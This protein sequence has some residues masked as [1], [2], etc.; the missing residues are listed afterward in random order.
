MI[1]LPV[2]LKSYL[3]PANRLIKQG[4]VK[5]VEFSGAT[6]QV[7]VQESEDIEGVWAFMQLDDNGGIKDCFCACDEGDESGACRHL[8]AAYLTIYR[9]N[10][11]P[12]HARFKRSLWHVLCS[13]YAEKVGY[14]LHALQHIS[15]DSYQFRSISGKPLFSIKGITEEGKDR[16]HLLMEARKPETEET[17]LKFSNLPQGEIQLRREGRPSLELLYHLSFWNDLAKWMMTL[18]VCGNP[19]DISFSYSFSGIPNSLTVTFP[20]LQA[21]FY[22]PEAML[23]RLIPSLAY[24]KSPIAVRDFAKEAID[25]IIYDEESGSLRV[26][27]IAS[28]ERAKALPDETL[29]KNSIRLGEWY[30]SPQADIFYT[31]AGSLL[32]SETILGQDIA[33]LLGSYYHFVRDKLED[34]DIHDEAV[35]VSYQLAFDPNWNLRIR[36]YLFEPGD[37][38]KP[39]SRVMDDWAYLEG[40]GFYRLKGMRSSVAEEVVSSKEISDFVTQNRIWLAG[41]EGFSPHLANVEADLCYD[42]DAEGNLSFSSYTPP[43]D[44]AEG[45]KDFG[46]WIYVAG[47]GFFSRIGTQ[48]G[49]PVRPGV[50]VRSEAVGLFIHMNRDELQ[51]VPKFFSRLCPVSRS[52]LRIVLAKDGFIEV[53]PSYDVLEEYRE[54]PLMFFSDYVYVPGEGFHSL[55]NDTLLPE[56]YRSHMRIDPEGQALFLNYDLEQLKPYIDYLDPRLTTPKTIDLIAEEIEV[57]DQGR[58]WYDIRLVYATDTGSISVNEMWRGMASKERFLYTNAGLID[59]SDPR[60]LWLQGLAKKRVD[61]RRNIVTLSTM[62]LIRLNVFDEVRPSTKRSERA[63]HARQLLKELTSFEDPEAPDIS[64]L[65]SSLRPYQQ[66]GVNWLWFL[67]HHGLSGLLCDD[68]GL[69][70]THQ[71]MAVMAAIISDFKLREFTRTPKFLVICPTSVIYHWQEKL[72][73][74]LPGLRVHVFYGLER[75]LEQYDKECHVLL[76][77]YGVWRREVGKLKNIHFDLAVFDEVQSAKSQASRLHISL[78]QVN[79]RM[80]LGLTGTPIE[81]RLMELKA[82]FDVVLPTYMPGER[83]YREFFIKPIER[84]LDVSRRQLLTRLVKPFLIRRKKEDVLVDLPEKVEEVFHCELSAEQRKLYREVLEEKRK[85]VIDDLQDT[86]K[87]VPYVHIFAILTSLK[88][89]CNHPA[90]YL[91]T[92]LDYQQHES[93]KWD[94]FVELLS[95]ARDSGQ[96]VVVFSQYLAML[97]IFEEYLKAEGIA[98]ASIRG[99]TTNRGEELRRFNQDPSCEVFLGSL[100]AVGLGVDLTAASVVIHYDRWWNAARENQA[101]D[102]VHRIGQT[103]GVQVFKLVTKNTFEERIDALIEAKGQLMEDVIG[104]DDQDVVKR[105]DRNELI[106]LLQYVDD[107]AGVES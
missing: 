49:I 52:A 96:K 61:L 16:L 64:G 69:G 91:N 34:I 88:R 68:M 30:Y 79:A 74:F 11:E 92:P 23:P 62:E 67:Y 38:Q 90:V 99:S 103:R 13:H 33:D 14:E 47:Q 5:D 107:A 4:A 48:V 25:K 12:L 58:G 28:K 94:L 85:L 18:Q 7:L 65:N 82:L 72:Q 21:Y 40:D 45:Q 70:K 2:L 8:T 37:L 32:A 83:E 36:P 41:R 81:N 9:D 59:L 63:D 43:E 54:K 19:Y 29:L 101:T 105:L 24:V 20:A 77:S 100:Q 17:S 3:R 55:P 98:F 51:L 106:Q 87:V 73:S 15:D 89:I 71:S 104:V 75:S 97:D 93:G 78:L 66:V 95:E 10:T 84:D 26:F 102:R 57:G 42:V 1:E 60:Y 53:A 56:E 80:R 46:R 86:T 44:V 27:R 35:E 50:V 39:R 76:T 22:T 31:E 6:Y